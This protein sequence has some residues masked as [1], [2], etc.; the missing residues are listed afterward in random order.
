MGFERLTGAKI[1]ACGKHELFLIFANFAIVK[2][3]Y[4]IYN[5]GID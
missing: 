2:S 3:V 1:K 4:S 5:N